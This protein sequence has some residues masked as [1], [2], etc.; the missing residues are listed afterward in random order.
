MDGFSNINWSSTSG[1]AQGAGNKQPANSSFGSPSSSSSANRGGFSGPNYSP[2]LST[3]SNSGSHF[4]TQQTRTGT[5]TSKTTQKDDPFGELVSFTSS[6]SNSQAKMTLRERQQLMQEQNKS[7][8]PSGAQQSM[9]QK[10]RDMW[11]FDVL[12]KAGGSPRSATPVQTL[13]SKASSGFMSGGMSNNVMDFD[14]LATTTPIQQ[15]PRQATPAS[16]GNGGFGAFG[17][18]GVNLLDDDEPIPMDITPPPQQ[19]QQQRQQRQQQ[20]PASTR[21]VAQQREDLFIDK[22]FEIAKIVDYGFTAEQAKDALEITGTTGKAIQLLREQQS[23][24]QQMASRQRS[25]RPMEERRRPQDNR[26]PARYEDSSSD[27]DNTSG[28]QYGG[29]GRNSSQPR[30]QGSSRQGSSGIFG[31]KPGGADALLATANELGT[32]MWKQANTWFAMGKKKIIEMQ[33]TVMDQRRP[34]GG[35]GKG[36]RDED[37]LPSAQ[38]YRDSSSDDDFDSRDA[39]VSPN[40]RGYQQQQQPRSRYTDYFGDQHAFMASQQ[41]EQ[42]F[43]DMG[44]DFN[45]PSSLPSSAAPRA[46]QPGTQASSSA[47]RNTGGS[48]SPAVTPARQSPRQ[49]TT[50]SPTPQPAQVPTLPSHVQQTIGAIKTK[51]ND[52][53]KLGQFGDAIQGYTEA[54]AQANQQSTTHPILIL[55]YNNRA[56][57]YTRNGESK[58]ALSD[59]TQSLELCK[60]YQS[61]GI[62]E[63]GPQIGRV[64]VMDQR[65]KALQRRGEALEA[66][67]RYMEALEDWKALREIARDG[68]LRQQAGRGVQRCEK[69]LG[70]N[71]PV[72]KPIKEQAPENLANVF[73]SISMSTVKANGTTGSAGDLGNTSVAVAAMRRDEKVKQQEETMRLAIVDQVDMEIKQWR[74][75][76]QQNLRAL[77]TSLHTLLPEFKPIGMHEILEPNKVKQFRAMTSSAPSSVSAVM[78]ESEESKGSMNINQQDSKTIEA[79]TE[80]PI[81]RPADCLFGWIPTLAVMVNYMFIFGASNSYGVFS[82]YYLNE[83][84]PDTSATTLSW[85]GTLITALMLGCNIATGALADKKGYRLTAYIGTVLCTA[86]YILASFAKEVWQLILSQGVL[87]G[88]GASFLIAPS[89]AIPPQWFNKHKALASGVAVAGSSFGGLWFTAATQA[90]IDN[91]GSAWALRILGILTFAV[92]GVM[93]LLYFRRVPAKPRKNLF[94]L[95]AAKQPVFWMISLEACAIYTGYWALTFYIGTTARQLGGTFQDGSNLLLVLNAGSAVGRIL[96]GFIADKFGNINTLLVSLVLTVVIEMPLWMTAKSIGPLYAL[97][98]LYGMISP[99]FISINPVIVSTQFD[100][101]VMASVMGMTNLFAGLGVLAGNLSQGAIFDKYDHREKFTNTIIFSGMFILFAAVVVFIM[102]AYAIRKKLSQE[103]GA[104]VSWVGSFFSKI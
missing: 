42:S 47:L 11:N 73:A 102:R 2:S 74:D 38:P 26:Q 4:G 83:K 19:Q 57:A 61:N 70:I 91:L 49:P 72:A 28:Y 78:R 85:I 79:V 3:L 21:P 88:I 104:S 77:L 93:N 15:Q 30:N 53:F 1:A 44:G 95:R 29:P 66:G 25:S 84:F 43:M 48:G 18:S 75:G 5:A 51:A 55:L 50:A 96:A 12:E 100:S 67:E 27:D 69:A 39:Y 68:T 86:A 10:Q 37:Y 64:D 13:Q 32:N 59:C 14:P 65:A 35:S 58:N 6:Q 36:W 8:L 24:A 63:L 20:S 56:L 60:R 90:M 54:V 17:S 101:D 87:F 92:T 94:E 34:G 71:Q 40:R 81:T 23:T 62:I 103:G 41:A 82:T 52:Q 45:S 22:D 80:Q 16:S 89:L 76:K 33:E 46:Q 31:G 98:I 9:A 97:C 7:Q 99:T